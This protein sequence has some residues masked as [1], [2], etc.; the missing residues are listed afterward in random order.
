[1]R[2]WGWLIAVSPTFLPLVQ[3]VELGVEAAVLR[4]VSSWPLDSLYLTRTIRGTSSTWHI[5]SDT[6]CATK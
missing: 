3:K 2:P 5:S 4:Q 6:L 1:M